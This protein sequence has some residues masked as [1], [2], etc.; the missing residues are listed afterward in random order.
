[1][2]L[3]EIYYISQI[4]AVV[5]MLPGT[6]GLPPA[7]FASRSKSGLEARASRR[8]KTTLDVPRIF[9]QDST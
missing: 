8:Q 3:E 1:M 9:R 6:A 2:T 4:V 5:A 7:L